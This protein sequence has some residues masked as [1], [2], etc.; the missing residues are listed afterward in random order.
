MTGCLLVIFLLPAVA[1]THQTANFVFT[2]FQGVASNQNGLPNNAYIFF[3]GMLMAAFTCAPCCAHRRAPCSVRRVFCKTLDWSELRWIEG[4][5]SEAVQEGPDQQPAH[6]RRFTGYD[7]CGHM[8][9]ET[10]TADKSAAYGIILS[11]ATTWLLGMCAVPSCC[12]V[13]VAKLPSCC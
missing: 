13:P 9:E 6:V 7:A 1:P 12:A 8:S 4:C 3:C 11:I 5:S 2:D 10:K